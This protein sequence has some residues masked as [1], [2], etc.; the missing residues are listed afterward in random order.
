MS[1]TICESLS[2]PQ[3]RNAVIRV[4]PNMAPAA[5]RHNHR[6]P[7]ECFEL[8]SRT[9]ES[10]ILVVG[11][12]IPNFFNVV[13]TLCSHQLQVLVFT[14]RRSMFSLTT[15]T[16]TSIAILHADYEKLRPTDGREAVDTEE[17]ALTRGLLSR[18]AG[19]IEKYD[20]SYEFSR[21]QLPSRK[22]ELVQY[23]PVT[24]HSTVDM[25]A[26]SWQGIS[27]RY[28]FELTSA[29]F[30]EFCDRLSALPVVDRGAYERNSRLT[31]LSNS[32][33]GLA[34]SLNENF[35]N[36]SRSIL[37]ERLMSCLNDNNFIKKRRKRR[38]IYTD[39][40]VDKQ[41]IEF[42]D[43]MIKKLDQLLSV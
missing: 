25:K 34:M 12:D 19:I 27:R 5:Y 24:L 3:L 29:E 2:T 28:G 31:L 1:R 9:N 23:I 38:Y 11:I 43:Q 26:V 14:D 16:G 39:E 8:L 13:D 37:S 7:T 32:C 20:F 35:G 4:L 36:V 42:Y 22:M 41:R 40:L 6:T 18:K 17:M 21:L 15:H 30:S 10:V 33:D